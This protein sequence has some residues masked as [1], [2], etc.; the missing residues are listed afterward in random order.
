[1]ESLFRQFGIYASQGQLY[2]PHDAEMFL[3]YKESKDG[4]IL[5][6]GITEAGSMASFTAAGTAYV[7]LR[8]GDDS[9]LHL[10]LHVRVPARGRPDLGVRRRARQGLPV[11]RHGRPHHARRRGPAAPGRPQPGAGQHRAH[12]RQLTIRRTPTRS[13]SSCRTASGAC[14]RSSE[15]RFYYLTLYNENYPMPAMPRGRR[16]GR[17]SEGHL[18]IPGRARKGKAEVQL[19]GSGPILNEALRA[20]QTP[21][22]EIRRG[23]RRVERDQLQRTAPRGA[24]G[25]ALE[26]AASGRA[27]ATAVHS[28]STGRRRRPHRGRHRLHEG[29]AGPAGAVA[30]RPPRWRW[31]P[32]RLRPQR[33]PRIPAAALRDQCG[34]DRRWRRFPGWRATASSIRSG[35]QAFAEL[36]VERRRSIRH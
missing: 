23:R 30:G 15:D 35:R 32:I 34:I 11:R 16:P 19:F 1:M 20:Q 29:G 27:A 9:V 8:R 14:T 3:Y 13:P 31:A 7:E 4:Q 21:G 24:G 5:E 25:G 33:Q 22:G 28:A 18:P 10:L 6:E 17:H 2:K 26:P 36:G 12:L